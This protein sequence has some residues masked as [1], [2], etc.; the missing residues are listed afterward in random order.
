V[1]TRIHAGALLRGPGFLHQKKPAQV[2]SNNV[3]NRKSVLLHAVARSLQCLVPCYAGCNMFAP[4]SP[5][6]NA[7]FNMFAP[8]SPQCGMQY[9]CTKF[10]TMRDAIFLHQ[11]P[12]NAGYQH[13]TKF[14]TLLYIT[15]I[16]S[17][18]QCAVLWLIFNREI[19]DFVVL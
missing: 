2:P 8:S 4:S 17:S 18:S 6:C 5:H 19:I 7:G 11:V 9:V 14:S 13:F 15:F 12:H 1:N 10:P 3:H 16:Q